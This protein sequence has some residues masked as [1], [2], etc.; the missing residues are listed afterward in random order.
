MLLLARLAILGIATHVPSLREM[1]SCW[2]A[3]RR[4]AHRIREL[5]RGPQFDWRR[6]A[7]EL[8][9]TGVDLVAADP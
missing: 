3:S 2:A 6:G 1:A 5:M 7:P 4:F 8:E 9:M